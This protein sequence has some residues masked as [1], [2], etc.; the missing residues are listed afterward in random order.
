MD[1]KENKPKDIICDECK[2]RF[3]YPEGE[4]MYLQHYDTHRRK[5]LL[6]QYL[7]KFNKKTDLIDV[8]MDQEFNN[9][10]KSML[11]K[12]L[13]FEKSEKKLNNFE[14]EHIIIMLHGITDTSI[15]KEHIMKLKGG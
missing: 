13:E 14:I 3:A 8:M 5:N 2:T 9:K 15:I 10:Y 12:I 4:Q 7:K 11:K 1:N 6:K